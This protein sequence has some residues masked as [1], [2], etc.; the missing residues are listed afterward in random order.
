[1]LVPTALFF[2][3]AVQRMEALSDLSRAVSARGQRWAQDWRQMPCGRVSPR[4]WLFM[5]KS[6]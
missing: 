2:L 4:D 3:E 5:D 6:F 1:M